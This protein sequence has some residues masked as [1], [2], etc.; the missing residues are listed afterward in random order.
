VRIVF[1]DLETTGLNP[2][3]DLILEV[4][5]ALVDPQLNPV[6]GFSAV[7]H[8]PRTDTFPRADA[9]VQNMHTRNGLWAEC[10]A[11][12][13][14]LVEVTDAMVAWLTRI[15]VSPGEKFTL[16]GDSVHFDLAFLRSSMLRVADRFSHRLLDVS[17]FRVAREF[18]GAPGCPIAGADVHRAQGDVLA[19]I[20]KARWHL[21][22]VAS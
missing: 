8:R 5:A 6:D 15:S 12:P 21:S 1:L 11:A 3:T 22:R 14:G 17:A 9:F 4:A 13:H 2:Q 7:I 18:I 19:S 20:A 10:D 16:A